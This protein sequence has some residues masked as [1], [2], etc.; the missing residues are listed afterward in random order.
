MS[1][2][3][4]YSS[5]KLLELLETHQL[6][7]IS[8]LVLKSESELTGRTEAEIF[9]NMKKRLYIM[10]DSIAAGRDNEQ[11][12]KSGMIG[13]EAKL[14]Q[15]AAGKKLFVSEVVRRATEYA[16]GV[17]EA[18]ACMGRVVAA[19]TAGSAG[20][21]PGVLWAIHECWDIPEEEV[22]RGLLTASGI[23]I[24]I[25][26]IATFSAAE[27]GCQAEIGEIGR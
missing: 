5:K 2:Y 1:S 12:S 18:N 15:Q 23:G 8:D 20:I 9:E 7:R 19:P 27:A 17:M 24:V 25:A 21:V 6:L 22:V 26:S 4:F 11:R 16:L 13:G 10:R 14:V 3:Q